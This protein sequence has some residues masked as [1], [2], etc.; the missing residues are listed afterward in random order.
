MIAGCVTLEAGGDNRPVV[1]DCL[2][3]NIYLTTPVNGV[4]LDSIFVAVRQY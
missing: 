1:K 2:T 4:E 3:Q